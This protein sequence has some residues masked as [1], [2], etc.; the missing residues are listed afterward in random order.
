MPRAT[1][2][3]KLVSFLGAILVLIFGT[4]TILSMVQTKSL[5]DESDARGQQA[6]QRATDTQVTT[7]FDSF[8][9]GARR[10]IMEGDMDAFQLLLE[11]LSDVD[12]VMEI[13]LTG[14]EGDILY[15]GTSGHTEEGF[16]RDDFEASVAEAGE[17]HKE[18]HEGS[19][20]MSRAYLMDEQCLDCHEGSPGDLAGVLYVT[21]DTSDLDALHAEN[22]AFAQKARERSLVQNVLI[23]VVALMITIGGIWV[24]VRRVICTPLNALIARARE[25]ASGEADLTARIESDGQDELHDLSVAFNDFLEKIRVAVK[26]VTDSTAE[27]A[28]ASREMMQK[29]EEVAGNAQ[30]TAQKVDA[31]T[32]ASRH[33]DDSVQMVAAASEEMNATIQEVAR[34]AEEA[35]DVARQAVKVTEDSATSSSQ[36]SESSSAIGAVIKVIDDIAEQTNLLALNATIE[37]ARAGEAGKGFAVV[38][39]EVKE[40]ASQTGKATEDI[41]R[42]VE[43]IQVDSR[44]GV[45]AMESIRDIV[46]R[47]NDI[48]DMISSAMTEQSATTSEIA[49]NTGKAA[50]GTGEITQNIGVVA[51]AAQRTLHST[52][53]ITAASRQVASSM[54]QIERELA[55]F[56]V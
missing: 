44:A 29:A 24:L 41:Q 19:M 22:V 51:D 36:L 6:L 37:A 1:I 50:Q 3:V 21:Y 26:G 15:T 34:N 48:A 12:G 49:S 4:V 55:T 45:E 30:E 38:A 33:I 52:Q 46:R 53:A 56:K 5:L 14:P 13:G 40:L 54:E 32:S 43:G 16:E 18:T 27:L 42:R 31:V 8:E 7:V 2:Q 11:D 28:A 35:Y 17:L 9:K 39:S 47:I 10:S 25:M 20:H 23:G